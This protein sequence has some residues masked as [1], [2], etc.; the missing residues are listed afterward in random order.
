MR[1]KILSEHRFRKP[2]PGWDPK[3]DNVLA[4]GEECRRR[5]DT[6]PT[7]GPAREC[8]LDARIRV[9]DAFGYWPVRSFRVSEE[10]AEAYERLY[11]IRGGMRV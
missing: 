2:V 6:F 1:E 4:V 3:Y 8:L 11:Q 7:V 10:A 9:H 5:V